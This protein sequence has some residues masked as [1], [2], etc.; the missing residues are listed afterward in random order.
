MSIG[1]LKE[2]NLS[3]KAY[4]FLTEVGLKLPVAEYNGIVA[5]NLA[6]S[7][8]K[9]LFPWGDYSQ[10][11][12]QLLKSTQELKLKAL[13]CILLLESG[14]A[15]PNEIHREI[16]TVLSSLQRGCL[17]ISCSVA[18][19]RALLCIHGLYLAHLLDR[20][21]E[22]TECSQYLENILLGREFRYFSKELNTHIFLYY[23]TQLISEF[24]YLSFQWRKELCRIL[25]ESQVADT[26]VALS[27]K[28]L[29]MELLE[30]QS[31]NIRDIISHRQD[32]RGCFPYDGVV[33]IPNADI[34]TTA[35]AFSALNSQTV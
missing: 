14:I 33:P 16:E 18:E 25:D 7:S 23:F 21:E 24:P 6:S 5:M 32:R 3:C 34:L 22:T 2:D 30:I 12:H 1:A 9:H 17:E 27:S 31:E 20:E 28:T 10:D 13:C 19:D 11:I 4:Q 26:T 35:F 29:C 8:A 15:Q